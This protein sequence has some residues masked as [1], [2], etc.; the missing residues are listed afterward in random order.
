MKNPERTTSA[1]NSAVT[2]PVPLP[3][4]MHPLLDAVQC[5]RRDGQGKGYE[6]IHI[7]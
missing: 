2:N 5:P 7:C 6:L 3:G 1:D 4:C